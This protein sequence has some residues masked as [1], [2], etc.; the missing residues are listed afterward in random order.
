MSTTDFVVTTKVNIPPQRIADV[1][2]AGV[3]GGVNYWASD[4]LLK[5]PG[6]AKISGS[7][8]YCNCNLYAA[9]DFEIEVRQAED[10][11]AGRLAHTIL[12]LMQA[13]RYAAGLSFLRSSRERRL[14][15]SHQW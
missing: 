2:T 10:S 4:F 15:F 9:D 11:G 3:E 7:P 14:T 1:I 6:A 13:K 12:G 5:S 8:W